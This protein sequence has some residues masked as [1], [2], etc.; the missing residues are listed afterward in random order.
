MDPV[1]YDLKSRFI[2]ELLPLRNKRSC[3]KG[4]FNA[5]SKVDFGNNF[6]TLQKY[7]LYFA[8]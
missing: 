8:G 1:I 4:Y 6:A 7:V 3:S 2:R 5:M